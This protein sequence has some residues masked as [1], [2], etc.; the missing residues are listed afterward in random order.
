[1]VETKKV[2]DRRTLAFEQLSDIA[3]DIDA[4]DG[5]TLRSTGN[6]TP[7]QNLQHVSKI[8]QCSID[9]FG[10]AKAPLLFRT[11]ARFFKGVALRKTFGAG[12]KLPSGLSQFLP[13]DDVTWEQATAEFRTLMDRLTDGA[14]MTQRSPV[15]GP[16]THE[17]WVRLHCRHAEL[18]LSFVHL[19]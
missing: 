8:I 14:R 5:Q 12:F 9:G 11:I 3:A 2:T 10:D 6:W 4:L 13:D 7:A 15:L 16:M 17:D 18:H 1:M 19:S